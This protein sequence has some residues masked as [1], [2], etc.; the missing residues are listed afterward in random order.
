MISAEM[1]SAPALK[2]STHRAVAPAW[3]TTVILVVLLGFSALGAVAGNRLSNG[4][5]PRI[6]QYMLVIVMEWVLVGFIWSSMGRRGVRMADLIGGRW[7]RPLDVFRDLGI[8]IAFIIVGGGALQGLGYLM[9]AAPN[10][11]LRSILPKNGTEIALW[12]V[13]SMTAGFC[14]ELV[15]RGYLTRQFA[16]LTQSAA[17]GIVL[18]GIVFGA[19]HGYQGWKLML[20]ITIYGTM[21]GLLAHW[22]RS[23]RP[24][25]I[26]HFL[27]DGV[28]GILGRYIAR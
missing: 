17:A 4:P 21:F 18:Q 7:A 19:A 13:M 14:E 10:H 24:G 15:F 20:I 16:A 2:K 1:I 5:L 28:G 12:M 6:A 26:A 11:V 27:Q 3:H 8:G 22:L 9:K 23:L 25:M